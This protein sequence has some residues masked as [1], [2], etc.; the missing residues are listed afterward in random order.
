MDDYSLQASFLQINTACSEDLATLM[1]LINQAHF[2]QVLLN[3]FQSNVS[4]LTDFILLS[5]FVYYFIY[6]LLF[7]I[8]FSLLSCLNRTRQ[9]PCFLV[10][11]AFASAL[12]SQPQVSINVFPSLLNSFSK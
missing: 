5:L 6:S 7:L 8:N 12:R 2:A 1:D 4:S 11:S 3:H 10:L 9:L